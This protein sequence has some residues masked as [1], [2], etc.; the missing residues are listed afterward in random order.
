[1]SRPG[2]EVYSAAS[3]PPRGAPTDTSVAFILSEAET[4]PVD[5]PTRLTSMD[6]YTRTYGARLP[7]SYGYDSCDAAFHDGCTTIYFQRIDD[8]GA[9]ATA[10]ATPI[11]GG[12]T[13]DAASPG[14]WGN[15]LSVNV[16]LAPAGL[17]GKSKGKNGNGTPPQSSR[18]T[19]DAAPQA[20]GQFMVTVT[21][22]GTIVQTSLPID[23]DNELAAFLAGGDYAVLTGAS[24][25][26]LVVGAVALA[27]GTN[28]TIPAADVDALQAG[29][30]CLT[31]DLGPGQVL[32]P[33]RH[34]PEDHAA[35]LA[36]AAGT[37]MSKVNRVAFLDGGMSTDATE[38]VTLAGASRG[39]Q[40][41]RYGALWGP[42]AV[43]PGLAPGTN[44]VVPWS[45]L[46]A[47]ICA[48]S[49]AA[50]NPNQAAAGGFGVSQYAIDLV[51]SFT[52]DER[53]TLLYAGVNTAR[54]V[55]GSVEAYGFRTL[56]DPAGPRSQWR[57]LN[58]ARLNM[59]I[60]A[61]SNVVGESTVF[62]QIDGRGHTIAKFNGRLA[63]ML[64]GFYDDD[65][66]F[67]ET[68]SDAFVVNTGPAVNTPDKLADGVLSA[69]LS[70]R[71]SPHAELV[72][73]YIVK[74]PITVT[75]A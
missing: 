42:W 72:Q 11:A 49:D 65:A 45:A 5:A 6:D 58:H 2:V 9:P 54:S 28:G 73:I 10:D 22:A 3:A 20:A 32:A 29:L 21:E 47:G 27:G 66:L 17:S 14:T 74:Y 68:A 67:G 70:V 19:Y 55:Y 62:A 35:L 41:D 60:V 69:V 46:Q 13:L 34:D 8:G 38:L 51:Q 26:A 39:A 61:Q 57:E 36:H 71:M 64:K 16:V 50:G 40:E 25:N 23:T 52:D 12:G 1:M 33:G 44:R 59:A 24:G 4:G 30:D 37:S 18:L 63:A 43:I 7:G 75:L 56:V 31:A 15:D 53:E 48:R